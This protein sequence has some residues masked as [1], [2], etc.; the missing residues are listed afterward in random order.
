MT[1]AGIACSVELFNHGRPAVPGY[2]GGIVVWSLFRGPTAVR[3]SSKAVNPPEKPAMEK[4]RPVPA[5]RS[6]PQW[7]SRVR[8][9]SG[10]RLP[11]RYGAWT[12]AEEVLQGLPVRESVGLGPASGSDVSAAGRTGR[13]LCRSLRWRVRG[14]GCR[15]N[16]PNG[17]RV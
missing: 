12:P 3:A 4:S 13:D 8:S 11:A 6:P 14:S 17:A 5:A 16:L 1:V 7:S 9:R 15:G 10:V 2:G